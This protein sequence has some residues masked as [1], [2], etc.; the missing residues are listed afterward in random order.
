MLFIHVTED[1][2]PLSVLTLKSTGSAGRFDSG[3]F[4]QL[5]DTRVEETDDIRALRRTG[6]ALTFYTRGPNYLN[7]TDT[8]IGDYVRSLGLEG[9]GG[10]P[11]GGYTGGGDWEDFSHPPPATHWGSAGDDWRGRDDPSFAVQG[12]D[13]WEDLPPAAYEGGGG[14]GW[15]SRTP[16]RGAAAAAATRRQTVELFRGRPDA[17]AREA[18]RL[19]KQSLKTGLPSPSTEWTKGALQTD[20]GIMYTHGRSDHIREF[21]QNPT[22]AEML[23]EY[24]KTGA[25]PEKDYVNEVVRVVSGGNTETLGGYVIAM[26]SLNDS[27]IPNL[28]R[29]A[30]KEHVMLHAEMSEFIGGVIHAM[31][32]GVDKYIV[33]P[34]KHND[35]RVV[36]VT[37]MAASDGSG[38]W[39]PVRI[40]PSYFDFGKLL[41]PAGNSVD[42]AFLMY[43]TDDDTL[44]PFYIN[45]DREYIGEVDH[46]MDLAAAHHKNISITVPVV[47]MA[48]HHTVAG[49]YTAHKNSPK[50]R[51]MTLFD[52]IERFSGEIT[53]DDVIERG[54]FGRE[55]MSPAYWFRAMTSLT[56]QRAA[57]TKGTHDD[58]TLDP[59]VMGAYRQIDHIDAMGVERVTVRSI[60]F[61]LQHGIASNE[62]F[63]C[64]AWAQYIVACMI[65]SATFPNPIWPISTN[66]ENIKKFVMIVAI[67]KDILTTFSE[68]FRIAMVTRAVERM[69]AYGISKYITIVVDNDVVGGSG[70]AV[71]P[72]AGK[73]DVSISP[74][75]APAP[76]DVL[77]AVLGSTLSLDLNGLPSVDMHTDYT[78]ASVPSAVH[79][80]IGDVSSL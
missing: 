21:S 53:E 69:Y 75:D 39:A 14:R 79:D 41:R 15:G 2:V 42:T 71:V 43:L 58:T 59:Y 74:S 48:G 35:K 50:Y 19:Q 77:D 10:A 9:D 25:I 23:E 60:G 54:T 20:K 4:L 44:T 72:S 73:A 16:D 18:A 3:T 62:L 78:S 27:L 26:E 28:A 36:L 5:S 30:Y 47:I 29:E 57:I 63:M 67:P 12:G 24:K 70:A 45:G 33:L 80:V 37:D 38:N 46:M 22:S 55:A 68:E 61:D 11:Q 49:M 32:R 8:P 65:K 66:P 64:G 13:R 31:R 1:G 6:N 76:V 34:D 51:K 52:S 17:A 7:L 56:V 40:R